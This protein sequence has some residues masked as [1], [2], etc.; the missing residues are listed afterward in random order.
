MGLGDALPK[1]QIHEPY[2]IILLNLISIIREHHMTRL[3]IKNI[4]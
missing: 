4:H 2:V 3:V 1:L